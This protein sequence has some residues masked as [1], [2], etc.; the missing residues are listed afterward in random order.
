MSY[1]NLFKQSTDPLTLSE[2]EKVAP[3][4]FTNS[5]SEN[6]S[7]KYTFIPTTKILEDM[8]KE[9]W[10][11]HQVSQRKSKQANGLYTKHML[12]LRNPNVAK[13]GDSVP[14]IVLTNS[15]DGRNAFSLHAGLFRIVC[16]NGLIIADQTFEQTRIKHQWYDMNQVKELT[17]NVIKSVPQIA[18]K[19]IKFEQT[20]LNDTQR[21]EFAKNAI[22]LRW[23]QG[24][25]NITVED[26]LFATRDAD[27]GN[28]LWKVFNVVQEK[29]LRGGMIY[30]LPTGRQQTVRALT[31]IDEQVK[32]N[33]NLWNLAEAYL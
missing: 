31:N 12:R 1:S 19:M 2:I 22:R 8:E 30:N 15:H 28:S 9:G 32:V 14:E 3:S 4:V 24:H 18:G 27:R 17:D 13:I 25:D 20:L 33:K 7:D 11:V 21:A 26:M 23:S 16:S 5:P 29:L 10:E 6:V